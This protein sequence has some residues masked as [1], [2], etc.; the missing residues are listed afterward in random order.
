MDHAD[1]TFSYKT[2]KLGDGTLTAFTMGKKNTT[3]LRTIVTSSDK[4]VD[5]DGVLRS[6]IK[7]RKSVDVKIVVETKIRAKIGSV[8]T[9]KVPVR[10]S[11][12]GVKASASGATVAGAKC[13]VDLRI[14]I[15]KWTV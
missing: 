1:V 2:V 11:C 10:V 3:T 5:E 4:S 6:E 13:K 9:K 8:K 7:S 12:D 15:W 14:K